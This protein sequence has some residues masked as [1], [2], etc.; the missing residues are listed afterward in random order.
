LAASSGGIFVFGTDGFRV[1]VSSDFRNPK[2]TKKPMSPQV[3][4][5]MSAAEERVRTQARETGHKEVLSF[6]DTISQA[7]LVFGKRANFIDTCTEEAQRIGDA[8]RLA[9]LR[10]MRDELERDLQQFKF[11]A[12]TGLEFLTEKAGI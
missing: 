8:Q 4:T 12:E 3:R 5:V 7:R 10:E 2:M 9:E 11:L 6:L 1:P